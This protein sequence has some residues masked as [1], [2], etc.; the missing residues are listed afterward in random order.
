MTVQH[1]GPLAGIK[2]VE[3]GSMIAGPFSATLLADFGA[4]VIKVEQP[5]TGDPMR[6]IGPFTEGE[7]LWWN[8]EARNKRSITLDLHAQEGQELLR[9]LVGQV[10]VLIENFRPGTMERWGLGWER[11]SGINPKLIMASIS[12]YGQSGPYSQRPA[13]DRMAQAFAGILNMTGFPDRPPVRP[14]V[15]I[16]DYGTAVFAAFAIMMALYHRDARGGQGQQIDAAMF[17]A[18]FR[19][20]DNMV[21]C[22]DQLGAT[23]SRSGNLNR[24]AA[25]GDHFVTKDNRYLVVTV[26]SDALF[27]RLCTCMDRVDLITDERFS[28]HDARAARLPE[29]NG[30]VGDWVRSMTAQEAC[31]KLDGGQQPN[32]LIYGVE[33]IMA[34]PHYAFRGSIATV[35]HPRIGPIKMQG[36]SPRLLGTP[37]PE[38]RPAPTLGDATEDV[39]VNLLGRSAEE[40]AHLRSIGVV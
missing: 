13:Y 24:N 26:S 38:I 39:I 36:V 11:L 32:S 10:D 3:L 8:V 33:E 1:Q 4:E 25:P 12:G 29:I 35:Q 21:T 7:S 28:S 9:D 15:A 20:T 34:D 30:I 17:E 22:Y 37:A 14:G 23:R 19:L 5:G 6:Q 27:A 16:A 2:V 18:M 31:E 40:L